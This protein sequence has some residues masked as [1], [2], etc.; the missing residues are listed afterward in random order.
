MPSCVTLEGPASRVKAHKGWARDEHEAW[1]HYFAWGVPIWVASLTGVKLPQPPFL[2][3][4]RAWLRPFSYCRLLLL[5]RFFVDRG[6]CLP[7]ACWAGCP[8]SGRSP[9]LVILPRLSR[10]DDGF[11]GAQPSLRWWVGERG[12]QLS[13]SGCCVHCFCFDQLGLEQ[14][15]YPVLF[16]PKTPISCFFLLI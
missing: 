3:A 6:A 12:A 14:R 9:V 16:L 11:V 1:P 13:C 2:L 8:F 5:C 15:A 7:Q 4:V 10:R